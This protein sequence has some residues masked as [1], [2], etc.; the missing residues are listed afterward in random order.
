MIANGDYRFNADKQI[1]PEFIN[2]RDIYDQRVHFGDYDSDGFDRYG[3]SAFLKDGT[4]IG[5]GQGIDRAGIT[6]DEY[7]AMTDEEFNDL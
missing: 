6:E 5:L 2:G 1:P 4:F 7:L 3:Y